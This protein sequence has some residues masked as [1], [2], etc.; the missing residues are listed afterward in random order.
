MLP[1]VRNGSAP[2]SGTPANRVSSLLDR[3]FNDED[4]FV[5]LAPWTAPAWAMPLSLWQDEEHVYVELDAP[6]LTEED[7]DVSMHAGELIIRGERKRQ[8]E[9]PGYDTR[10]YGQFQQRLAL[11]CDVDA[12]N[13]QARLANGVL[14]LTFTKA[15]TAKPRKIT[16]QSA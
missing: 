1:A 4:L 8:H 12:Q 7:I 5:P 6:G 3:F 15:E 13:V 10:T 9:V 2:S 16:I 11:P 14:S